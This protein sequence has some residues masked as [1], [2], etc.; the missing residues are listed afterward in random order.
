MS[1]TSWLDWD[2]EAAIRRTRSLEDR[3]SLAF[4]VVAALNLPGIVLAPWGTPPSWLLAATSFGSTVVLTILYVVEARGLDRRR[5]W[6][7]LA[8]RPLLLVV[9]V[10]GAY[11]TYLAFQ[12]HWLKVPFDVILATWA[13][14]SLPELEP[15]G[16][17]EGHAADAPD[18]RAGL[19]SIALVLLVTLLQA[20]IW[21]GAPIFGWG[22]LLDAHQ[23]DLTASLR[24]DCGP[25]GGPPGTLTV[26]Y[27]WSWRTRAPVPS[28]LDVVVIGWKGVDGQGRALYLLGPTPVTGPGIQPS[29]Q[30]VP[31]LDMAR[32][33]EMQS[34]ASWHWGIHLDQQGMAPGHIEFQLDLAHQ[35]PP[36]PGPLTI[37]ASYVHLGLWHD[38]ATPVTCSW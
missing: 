25:G 34:S 6:A 7:L 9:A 33:I 12:E 37:T 27:D 29:F 35:D 16:G 22:G 20:T 11:S 14:I 15:P 8:A 19:R 38:D 18:T 23:A 32:E 21:Y 5:R 2:P 31:S 26:G 13:W 30:D 1:G 28:G 4:K 17:L 36:Q 3:A 10:F 24:V